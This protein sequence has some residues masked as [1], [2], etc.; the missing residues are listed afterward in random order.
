MAFVSINLFI[1]LLLMLFVTG[2]EGS[3]QLI[4]Q[5]VL[6]LNRG[7]PLNELVESIQNCSNQHIREVADKYIN[8]KCPVIS[9]VGPLDNLL[10]YLN[11]RTKTNWLRI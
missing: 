11:Y 7:L 1:D 5:S 4:G 9:A 10:T 6:A 3:C 8:N 2:T